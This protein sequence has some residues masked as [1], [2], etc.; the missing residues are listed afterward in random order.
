MPSEMWVE[1][2]RRLKD[3]WTWQNLPAYLVLQLFEHKG[4]RAA[5]EVSRRRRHGCVNVCV[6]IN[7]DKTQVGTLLGV[8]SYWPNTQAW[9]GNWWRDLRIGYSPKDPALLWHHVATCG[10]PPAWPAC[11]L[12]QSLCLWH[13]PASY[14]RHQRCEESS[15]PWMGR[16]SPCG[17]IWG[18]QSRGRSSLRRSSSSG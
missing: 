11:G 8:A 9:G 14:W 17:G 6:G 3:M 2:S 16:P 1:T 18:H 12:P 7:P 15:R 5:V 10:R 4:H 13:R